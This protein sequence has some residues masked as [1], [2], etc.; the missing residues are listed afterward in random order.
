MKR[1]VCVLIASSLMLWIVACAPAAPTPVPATSVPAAPTATAAPTTPPFPTKDVTFIIPVSP[2]GGFDT[3]AR[4]LAPYLKKYL[5]TQPNVVPKNVPG[6]EWRLGI[7]EMYKA[8]PDG[9]TIAIFNL[10][11]NVLGQITNTAEYDLNKVAWIGRITDTVYVTALSPKSKFRTLD[12]LRAAATPAKAG[13]VGLTSSSALAMILSAEE[14]GFKVKLINYDGSA[15]AILAAVRGDVDLVIYPFPT[16]QK[17]IVGSKDLTPFNVY[18]KERLKELPDVPTVGEQG[19]ASLLSVVALDYMVGTVPG[20]PE[21]ILK[22]W[23]E[24][25]DK[26]MKDPDF[27]KMMTDQLKRP[28]SPLNAEQ[29]ALKVKDT[30]NVYAKYKSLV[31][32]YVPK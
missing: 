13:V 21:P 24:T 14:M 28:P 25:F 10:P 6:G 9:H 15:D 32:Q 8:Q 3:N 26:A 23:R 4:I 1:N 20:T 22:I 17:F 31:E 30:L 29:A 7:M 16:L 18:A 19:Y 27:L 12:D 2:G 11:G 5:P